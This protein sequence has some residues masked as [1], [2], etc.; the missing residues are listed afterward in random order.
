MNGTVK[1][2]FAAS[3]PPLA[4]TG[5][6]PEVAV[7]GTVN[8]PVKPPLPSA[9]RGRVAPSKLR[10]I[11]LVGGKLEPVTV[12]AP[13]GKP[14]VGER[15]MVGGDV[16]VKEALAE[17]PVAP[18]AVTVTG[19][20]GDAGTVKLAEK[21]PEPLAVVVATCVEPKSIVTGSPTANA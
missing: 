19:P 5:Y 10:E 21:A 2:A 4:V 1:M 16:T 15:T 12:N 11:E 20:S 17:S 9:V 13:P 3:P 18:N 7:R 6:G 8:T 14:V